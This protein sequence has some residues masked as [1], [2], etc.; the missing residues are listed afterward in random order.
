M[1][2]TAIKTKLMIFL[3][4]K[5]K[6]PG[7]RKENHLN[8]FVYEVRFVFSFIFYMNMW[9][10]IKWLLEK[11]NCMLKFTNIIFLPSKYVTT[12]TSAKSNIFLIR[13]NKS[14]MGLYSVHYSQLYLL[15]VF[16]L[17]S[18]LFCSRTNRH[19]ISWITWGK[20]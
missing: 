15:N 16:C 10:F 9:I 20:I 14:F 4:I 17:Y 3:N 13:N 1:S 12:F 11:A 19:S 6:Y 5:S 2:T 7:S 18:I 8:N